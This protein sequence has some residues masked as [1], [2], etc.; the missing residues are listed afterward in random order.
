M[1]CRV[2]AC[3]I[4]IA[5][6]LSACAS[7]SAS[8]NEWDKPG[9]TQNDFSAARFAC[10]QQSQQ[11]VSSTFADKAMHETRNEIITN[12][13]L[14]NAC[15]TSQGWALQKRVPPEELAKLREVT[16]EFVPR[17]RAIC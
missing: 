2:I 7:L 9:A 17:V 5:P 3:V 4:A 12:S 13:S 8:Q 14:F 15:M 10:M 16:D 1:N 11:R 6:L